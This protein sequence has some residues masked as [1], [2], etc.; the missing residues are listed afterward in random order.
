MDRWRQYPFKPQYPNTNSPDWSPYISLK[1]WLREF[2]CISKL[3]PP[4]AYFI[5]SHHI[6]PWLCIDVVWRKLTLVT[7]GT[8]RDIRLSLFHLTL[9]LQRVGGSKYNTF[10]VARFFNLGNW[11]NCFSTCE[12]F[13]PH[14]PHGFAVPIPKLCSREPWVIYTLTCGIWQN[15]R[16]KESC[17]RGYLT[18][19]VHVACKE[20]LQR[21]PKEE[22]VGEPEKEELLFSPVFNP[23]T[24][25]CKCKTSDGFPLC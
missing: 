22:G 24:R 2:V 6:F 23:L 3:F 12:N 1:N 17:S 21:K 15:K 18:I 10:K 8:L 5:N 4:G 14:A 9:F 19:L 11:W 25:T 13:P 20:A 7:L 16:K